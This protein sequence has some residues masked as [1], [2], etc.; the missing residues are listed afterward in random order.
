MAKNT[1]N[2]KPCVTRFQGSFKQVSVFDADE[3]LWVCPH[4][5]RQLVGRVVK[6]VDG[7]ECYVT[8]AASADVWQ[9]SIF[10]PL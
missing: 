3:L 2:V 8:L 6:Q 5:G 4:N 1:K 7:V 10:Q 9:D